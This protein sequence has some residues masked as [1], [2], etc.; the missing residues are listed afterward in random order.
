MIQYAIALFLISVFLAVL[1]FRL[2]QIKPA[3]AYFYGCLLNSAA[4][5]WVLGYLA[6]MTAGSVDEK[7][8]ALTIQYMGIA[9]L[10]SLITAFTLVFVGLDRY[11]TPRMIA[12]SLLFPLAFILLVLTN[13]AHHLIWTAVYISADPGQFHLERSFG[14]GMELFDL[15]ATV[16]AAISLAAFISALLRSERNYR[17]NIFLILSSITLVWIAGIIDQSPLS[18]ALPIKIGPYAIGLGGI[19]VATGLFRYRRGVILPLAFE[20]IIRG[21][22]SGVVLTDESDRIIYTNSSGAEIVGARDAPLQESLIARGLSPEKSQP[23]RAQEIALDQ[24]GKRRYFDMK[25]AELADWRG[26]VNSH[27]YIFNDITMRKEVENQLREIESRYNLIASKDVIWTCDLNLRMTSMSPSISDFR[28][29]S[30]SEA[31]AQPMAERL[32]P[33]SNMIVWQRLGDELSLE[34]SGQV[35]RQRFISMELEFYHQDGRIIWGE[36]LMCVL[37]NERNEP[38]GILGIT[39]DINDRKQ[40]EERLK[41]A[42][43][44]FRSLFENSPVGIYS[45]SLDG[46]YLHANPELL[47]ILGYASLRELQ[48]ASVVKMYTDP[49]ARRQMLLNLQ[50]VGQ[51]KDVESQMRRRNGE[52]IWINENANVLFENDKEES[53]ILEGTIQD[54]TQRKSMERELRYLAEHDH[55]T[56]LHNRR[57]FESEVARQFNDFQQNGGASIL[58]WLDLDNFKEINDVLG[59]LAGDNLLRRISARLRSASSETT[60]LSRLGGDEFGIF[61]PRTSPEEAQQ[62]ARRYLAEISRQTLMLGKHPVRITCSIGMAVLPDHGRN[63]D[64][65]F[66]HADAALRRAKSLGAAQAQM[67]DAKEDFRSSEEMLLTWRERLRRALEEERMQLFAQPIVDLNTLKIASWE[68]LLRV[69]DEGRVQLPG[70]YLEMAS[71]CGLMPEIDQWVITR[72]NQAIEKQVQQKSKDLAFNINLS[73]ETCSA[74]EIQSEIIRLI[75]KE[76]MRNAKLTFEITESSAIQDFEAVNSFIQQLK[77]AGSQ[78]ALD[79]FGTGFSS[80]DYLKRLSLDYLKIDGKFI[81]NLEQSSQDQYLVKACVEIA[82]GFDLKT[83]AEV[84]ETEET[85]SLV[86]MLG[87]D[88]GQG[89]YFGKPRPLDECL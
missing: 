35:D 72:L 10:P 45:L 87:V 14:L 73:S 77:S 55:L 5:F 18:H 50:K 76:P 82:R 24:D 11:L 40:A 64:M 63:S 19:L 20:S 84:I 74:P 68:I 54:I 13:G 49:D 42:E 4:I 33:E 81:R 15:Y 52:I 37:R 59:H 21:M 57:H 66:D 39:R 34:R 47:S 58:L 86:K 2:I 79:D 43:R 89:Y 61:L 29:V 71:R 56:G 41:V 3:P 16:M 25:R 23:E 31:M 28:G 26:N 69:V 22:Q 53:A 12:L 1:A 30:A 67:Y 65:L 70:Q 6:E 44:G 78:V 60:L 51:L 46:R 36:T 38:T 8:I 17:Q 9:F 83:V 75:C 48:A 80:F 27:L 32:T 7:F 88:L 85:L 62:A